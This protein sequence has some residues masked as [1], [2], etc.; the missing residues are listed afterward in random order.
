MSHLVRV[1]LIAAL[2][3]LAALIPRAVH[4]NSPLNLGPVTYTYTDTTSCA[5]PLTVSGETTS[6]KIFYQDDH[7]AM[8]S[9][10]SE[11]TVSAKGIPSNSSTTAT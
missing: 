4:A 1:S 6:Q 9:F 10:H 5:F 2:L 3:S 11:G 7:S 8:L